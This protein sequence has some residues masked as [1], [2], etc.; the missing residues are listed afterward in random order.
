MV[1]VLR[2]DVFDRWLRHLKDRQGRLRIL[3]RLTRLEDGN[4][5]DARPIGNG[6]SELRINTGPGYRVYYLQNG[7]TLVL[8]LC[9]GD[10]STQQHDIDQAHRLADEWQAD[11]TRQKEGRS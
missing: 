3:S 7:N 4:H 6:L 5:G 8:L 11:Q 2:T 10:K 9:G 1:D